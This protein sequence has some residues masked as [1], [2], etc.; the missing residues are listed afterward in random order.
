MTD[1]DAAFIAAQVA[2][3]PAGGHAFLFAHKGFIT[4]NHA[5]TL[6]GSNPAANPALQNTLM[7]KLAAAG[8]RY[9]FCGHDHVHNRAIVASPDGAS[10]IQNI[11]TASDSYKFYVPKSPSNDEKYNTPRRETML[12]QELFTIG[13]SIVAV[14]G[15][16]VTV[17]SWASPSDCNGDCDL[18]ADV[19]PYAFSKRET[20]GHS[21]NGKEF[22]VPQGGS[23]TAVA[24]A[25]EGTAAAIL[26][27]YNGSGKAD[28]AGRKLAHAVDTGW[29]SR[30]CGTASATLSLWGMS[31]MIEGLAADKTDPF[32]LSMSFDRELGHWKFGTGEFGIQT[33]D[34]SGKWVPAARGPFVVGPWKPGY[35]LGAY[36]VDPETRTAWAVVDRQGD[37]RVASFDDAVTAQ[38]CALE[39]RKK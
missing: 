20:F 19:I 15:P 27:G 10:A 26:D 29:A 22:L 21:L 8:V 38:A 9:H 34:A 30:A 4:E 17:D 5:D 31:S 24:D 7:A 14:D 12:A 18:T 1:A 37:F 16:R 23:Y 36:G 33:R 28:Y 13:Y 32:V 39:A 35:A 2:A 3:R 6:F 11:I 25:F